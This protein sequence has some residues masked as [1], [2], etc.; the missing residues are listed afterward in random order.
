MA[1]ISVLGGAWYLSKQQRGQSMGESKDLFRE[2][3]VNQDQQ[4]GRVEWREFTSDRDFEFADL[5]SDGQVTTAE[6]SDFFQRINQSSFNPLG[7][8]QPIPSISIKTLNGAAWVNI[9]KAKRYT[10]LVFGSN[11]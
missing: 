6:W 5:D 10:V 8:G 4:I 1:A 7:K 11:T 9:S 2:L 3:D